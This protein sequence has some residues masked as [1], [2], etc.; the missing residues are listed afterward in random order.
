MSKRF[1][2]GWRGARVLL[3]AAAGA[4]ALTAAAQAPAYQPGVAQKLAADASTYVDC[5]LPGAVRRLGAGVTYLAARKPQ[6]LKVAECEVRGGEYVLYDRADPKVAFKI[7]ESAASAGDPD[8]QRRLAQ[9]Y[10]MGLTVEPD[11]KNAAAWYR[12]S[13]EQGNQAAA[14]ALAALYESGLGVPKDPE[15]ARRWYERARMP[16]KTRDAAPII[17][18]LD[19]LDRELKE[20]ERRVAELEAKLA[21]Q[22][23]ATAQSVQAE[24]AKAK[25][26]WLASMKSA[27]QQVVPAAL[28]ESRRERPV[29][30]LVDPNMVRA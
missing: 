12:K 28:L 13:A 5:L 10:E 23:A 25:E 22:G 6:T 9:I 3:C 7:W 16:S 20:K 21:S 11:Y 30:E 27:S 2:A 8:A 15:E 29:I 1:G 4:S 17:R 26:E 18:D 14:M 19:K 24:V